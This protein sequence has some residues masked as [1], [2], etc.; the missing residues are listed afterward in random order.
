MWWLKQRCWPSQRIQTGKAKSRFSCTDSKGAISD[1]NHTSAPDPWG[2]LQNSDPQNCKA[3][4]FCAYKSLNLLP[5]QEMNTFGKGGKIKFVLDLYTLVG[6]MSTETWLL[7]PT[8]RSHL[9]RSYFLHPRGSLLALMFC[10]S[11]SICLPSLDS[12]LLDTDKY[13]WGQWADFS[14][15]V[16]EAGCAIVNIFLF[17]CV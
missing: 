2:S 5:Q 12:S 7:V 10:S 4:H 13:G 16:L 9:S 6:L 8:L 14:L 1:G 3:I 11:R 15:F 17:G